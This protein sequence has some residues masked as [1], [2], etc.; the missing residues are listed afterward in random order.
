[1]YDVFCDFTPEKGFV[2][3]LI[4]SFSFCYNDEFKDKAFYEDYHLNQEA[5]TWSKF[6]L[7][8]PRMNATVKRSTHVRATCNFNIEELKYEDYLRAKLSDIDLMRFSLS[9]CKKFEFISV[10]GN[11]CTNDTA[12][13]VQRDF[14]HAHSDSN[15]QECSC[16]SLSE[17][18]VKFPGGE[19]NFGWY[20]TRNPVHRCVASNDSTTQWLFGVQY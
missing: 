6:R 8:L 12:H 10:R 11:N 19:D 2:W 7:S 13:F 5:F 18:A 1:M 16:T 15:N 20:K 9:T 4:E 17:G 14:W 3:T